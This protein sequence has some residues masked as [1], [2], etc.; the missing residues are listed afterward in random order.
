MENIRQANAGDP[1][2]CKVA[3]VAQ[4]LQGK[5]GVVDQG[6]PSWQQLADTLNLVGYAQLALNITSNHC[7]V[8]S[9]P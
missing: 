1:A 8:V 2:R 3:M 4:W 5:D 9:T 6:G 7:S